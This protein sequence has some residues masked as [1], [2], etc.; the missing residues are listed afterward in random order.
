MGGSK[1][2]IYIRW[3]VEVVKVDCLEEM[4]LDLF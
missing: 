2:S 3:G 1:K 4:V